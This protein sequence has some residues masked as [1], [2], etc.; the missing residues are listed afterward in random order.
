MQIS[1]FKELRVYQLAFRLQQEIF[2]LTKTFPNEEKY[3]LINQIRRSSRSVG[4]NIAEAWQKRRYIPHFISKLTDSDS[5][6][7]ETQHWLN[8]SLACNYITEEK[9]NKLIDGYESVGKML[10]KMIAEHEKWSI[11]D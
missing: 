7:S 4:A 8:T 1:S 2:E 11:N 6:Q 3:S 9:Y 5:E 10:G